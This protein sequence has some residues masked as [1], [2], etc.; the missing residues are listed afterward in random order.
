MGFLPAAPWR[1]WGRRRCFCCRFASSPAAVLGGVPW[2]RAC[3]SGGCGSLDPRRASIF[4]QFQRRGL[5]AGGGSEGGGAGWLRCGFAA[6][7]RWIWPPPVRWGGAGPRSGAEGAWGVSPADG[8]S[9]LSDPARRSW[10]SMRLF[11]AFGLGALPLQGAGLRV[12]A[13]FVVSGGGDRACWVPRGGR[14]RV[15][16][17]LLSVSSLFFLCLYLA[18]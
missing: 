5:R 1:W 16:A 6:S 11:N 12:A 3:F 2:R 8:R 18:L 15:A 14:R 4:R 13:F 9:P 17:V 10:W 7:W